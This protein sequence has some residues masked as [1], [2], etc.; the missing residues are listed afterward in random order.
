[1]RLGLG[2]PPP[3]LS[4][5][6]EDGGGGGGSLGR[7]AEEGGIL[8]VVDPI[9][10]VFRFWILRHSWQI[11]T[12]VQPRAGNMTGVGA[13]GGGVVLAPRGSSRMRCGPGPRS[14]PP[15]PPTPHVRGPDP[16]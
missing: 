15:V 13:G 16:L 3:S 4:V 14:E 8:V 11:L 7:G 5:L 9:L 6:D 10:A 1:M 12:W 2:P